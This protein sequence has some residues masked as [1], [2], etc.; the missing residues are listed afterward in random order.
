ME[1]T[2]EAPE[3]R[4]ETEALGEVVDEVDPPLAGSTRGRLAALTAWGGGIMSPAMPMA[5]LGDADWPTGST[6]AEVGAP[7]SQHQRAKGWPTGPKEPHRTR[8]E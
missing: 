2:A 7:L 4:V 1:K 3:A 6:T 8:T 5:S